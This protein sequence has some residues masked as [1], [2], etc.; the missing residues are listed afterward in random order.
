MVSLFKHTVS[1]MRI[2]T[3]KMK[4]GVSQ[5]RSSHKVWITGFNIQ[6]WWI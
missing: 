5:I 1:I 3:T 2:L 4:T 6:V